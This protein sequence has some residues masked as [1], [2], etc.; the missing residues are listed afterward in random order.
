MT[1]DMRRLIMIVEKEFRPL[2]TM[3]PAFR[4]WFGASKVVDAEGQPLMVYH[5]TAVDFG[6]FDTR[7]GRGKTFGTGAFFSSNPAT[8]SSYA[9]GEGGHLKPVYL[10]LQHPAVIDAG[11]RNWNRIGKQARIELPA[12][13]V[14]DQ[15]ECQEETK[16]TPHNAGAHVPGRDAV[17]R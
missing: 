15:A 14:S 6:A 9:G 7:G 3:S 16:S 8:A 1:T 4:R 5:G 2:Q 11:G 10:S 13:E 17:R 12:V